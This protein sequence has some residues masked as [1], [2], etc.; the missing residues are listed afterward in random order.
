MDETSRSLL[1]FS[2]A[3]IAYAG[4]HSLLAANCT[5]AWLIKKIPA[6]D[7]S[8]R[9][10]YNLLAIVL[11]IPLYLLYQPIETTLVWQRPVI[12]AGIFDGLAII[13]FAAFVYTL[14][15][16]DMGFFLGRTQWQNR[17]VS[18]PA[19]ETLTISGL[20]RFVR[21]PWYF[22]FLIMLW[23][24]DM[25]LHQLTGTSL[26]TLYFI[27]GSRLEEKKLIIQFGAPYQH[28]QKQVPGLIPRPW[29][30]LRRKI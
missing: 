29:R 27:I 1:I 26:I 5:K 28:Y 4:L 23:S 13:A 9:L 11:L 16:Y 14:K 24:Q 8:Y 18:N 19:A 10:I 22:L 21:H 3:F 25:Q 7:A 12:L 17:K 20:H 30:Y 15:H 6:I 2:L